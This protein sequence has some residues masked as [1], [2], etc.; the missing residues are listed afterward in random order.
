MLRVKHFALSIAN[1]A[2][3][4]PCHGHDICRMG[5]ATDHGFQFFLIRCTFGENVLDGG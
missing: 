2:D 4:M 1:P 5:L 3:E